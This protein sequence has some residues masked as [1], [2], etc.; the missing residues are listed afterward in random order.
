VPPGYEEALRSWRE[1]GPAA[2]LRRLQVEGAGDQL[3][4]P[5]HYLE[6]LILL[7][8]GR[9][10]QAM[11][12]FRRCTFAD[13]GFA[14]GYLAQAGLFTRAGEPRRARA[15]LE[16][17]ARLVAELDREARVFQGD[18]LRAGALRELVDAQRH[19]L[20]APAGQETVDA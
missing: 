13:P 12:A 8:R 9:A 7:D 1:D 2:A 6:G 15:A 3:I 18:E 17:A 11:A 5:L 10:D 16:S 14:L 4:A 20:G 19:L